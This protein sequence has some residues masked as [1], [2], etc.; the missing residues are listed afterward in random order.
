MRADMPDAIA[1]YGLIKY[2]GPIRGIEDLDLQVDQGEIFGFLGPNGA[3]KTTTIRLLL[4]L[5]RPTRGRAQILGFDVHSQ[6]LQVR[7]S[8]GVIPSDP[9]FF[10][11][12]R[13]RE[14]LA[15][16][17]SFH[18]PMDTERVARLAQRFDLDLDRPI[19]A[20]SRGMRQKLAIIQA[21]AHDP[22][23]LLLDEPT[24][25]LDPLMQQEF[26]RALQEEQAQGKTVFLSSH[27]LPEVERVCD[28]VAIVRDGHLV[29]V[30]HVAELKRRR[31]RKMEVL[32]QRDAHPE[33]FAVDGVQV[34]RCEGPRAEL[35]VTGHVAAVIQRLSSLPL[36]D[37]VFPEPTLEDV[38]FQFYSGS[39]SDEP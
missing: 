30:E 15:L 9:V 27:M 38:F 32:L 39:E 16:L 19:R 14:H 3:G 11:S 2:Y 22:A 26:Y 31:V 25:G 24:M 6:S 7:R 34:L 1:T 8:V 17:E 28:R 23:L 29:A 18:G 35:A 20:Y 37:L 10:D 21:L 36:E 13:G 4:D 12:L 5:I 33:D